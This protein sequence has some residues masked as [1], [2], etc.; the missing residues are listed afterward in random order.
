MALLRSYTCKDCGGVLNF[1]GDQEVFDCPFCGQEF[2]FTDF[3]RDELLNQAAKSLKELRYET[4]NEKYDTLLANNPQD[5]EALRG[6]VLVQGRISSIDQL[7]LPENIRDCDFAAAIK[8]SDEAGKCVDGSSE[9]GYFERL[10]KLLELGEEFRDKTAD[11]L[12]KSEKAREKYSAAV[13]GEKKSK[14]ALDIKGKDI[15]VGLTVGFGVL[16][17]VILFAIGFNITWLVPASLFAFGVIALIVLAVFLIHRHKVRYTVYN[18]PKPSEHVTAGHIIQDSL[19]E[20]AVELKRRYMEELALLKKEDP[21]SNGYMPPKAKKKTSANNPF[22]DIVKTVNCAKCGGQLYLDK[23]KGMFECKFCGVAYGTSLFFNNTLKKAKE[24]VNRG[25]FVEADQRFSHMLMVDPKDFDAL[26]GR[27][28]CAGKWKMIYD[29]QL[30]DKMLPTVCKNLKERCSEGVEHAADEDREF[31]LIMR[32]IAD[33]LE[34][35]LHNE[36]ALKKCQNELRTLEENADIRFSGSVISEEQKIRKSEI[37]LQIQDCSTVKF[38]L[39]DRFE[40]LKESLLNEK[41]NHAARV[42]AS[43]A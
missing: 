29:M 32:D 39:L 6:M 11:A 35:H 25:D 13:E 24:A 23:D 18:V 4:A 36:Q 16:F 43:E 12:D 34:E 14:E 10:T 40:T 20:E 33:V 1:E 15:G 17:Q 41:D 42:S 22:I 26:L 7:D 37:N 8:A 5:L 3:H 31:F 21:A 9:R 30:S 27:I 2:N 38:K 19:S 28:F